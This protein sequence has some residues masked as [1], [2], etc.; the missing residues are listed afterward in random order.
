MFSTALTKHLAHFQARVLQDALNEASAA[1][2]LRR[3]KAY[4]DAA[5]PRPAEWMGFQTTSAERAARRQR[6]Q[7]TAA[8]CRSKAAVC[9]LQDAPSADVWAALPEVS[10]QTNQH[11]DQH[12][13]RPAA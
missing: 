9:L 13:D 1:Y 4:E 12:A 7:E 2:W 3:A 11:V 5:R 10:P 8:A 6:M